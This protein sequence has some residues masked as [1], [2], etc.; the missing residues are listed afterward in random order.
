MA[1][2]KK[3]AVLYHVFYEDSIDLIAEE[4]NGLSDLSVAYFFNICSDT[5]NQMEIKR[6]LAGHFP[7]SVITI[8]SNKGKDI[9]GKLVMLNICIQAGFKPDWFIFLH[10]KKSLQALN[11]EIWKNDLFRIVAKAQMND[12]LKAIADEHCGIIAA[13]NYVIK[14]IRE[15]GKFISNN[16][17]LLAHLLE[18]YKI[19]SNQ[20]D[21]V[22]GTMF[23]AR[24]TAVVNFFS[25]NSPLKIRQT[26]EDGNVLDNFSGTITH[27]WERLFS[28]IIT[29]QGLSIK[30][31]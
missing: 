27:S 28:W 3:I 29:S 25:K 26:L 12:I 10:D 24:A 4:L 23:W 21:Y 22:G 13:N 6:R 5:P 31:V 7:G 11:P 30:T 18:E 1:L 14:E 19:E 16:G 17:P 9:G 2:E 8:S 20:F 15:K